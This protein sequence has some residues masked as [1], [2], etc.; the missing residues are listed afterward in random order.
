MR[1]N[2]EP[3]A[4]S[5]PPKL[6]AT[7]LGQDVDNYHPRAQVASSSLA[8]Q[9]FRRGDVIPTG[10][11]CGE[12]YKSSDG[13]FTRVNYPIAFTMTQI[14][15]EHQFYASDH[16]N[17]R[18]RFF[19]VFSPVLVQ[20]WAADVVTSAP[21]GSKMTDEV[22]AFCNTCQRPVN[23]MLDTGTF[24]PFGY[25]PLCKAAQT[26]VQGDARPFEINSVVFLLRVADK[27]TKRES[28]TVQNEALR[29]A[30]AYFGGRAKW[31]VLI[32]MLNV[33][34]NFQRASYLPKVFDELMSQDCC[35]MS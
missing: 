6:I 2:V 17:W 29:F 31:V 20:L 30:E 13:D 24:D 28:P 26:Y 23:T 33:I 25:W 11:D 16:R 9:L 32:L 22:R 18:F 15:I 8:K 14:N 34:W 19:M 7:Y 4:A 1:F 27:W 5:G 10:A 12:Q 21:N 3:A 35:L